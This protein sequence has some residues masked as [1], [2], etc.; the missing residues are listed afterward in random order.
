MPSDQESRRRVRHILEQDVSQVAKLLKIWVWD[1]RSGNRK[2]PIPDP[3][4]RIQGQKGT[5]SRIRIRNTI[6][7]HELTQLVPKSLPVKLNESDLT[8]STNCVNLWF[9]VDL[10]GTLLGWCDSAKLHVV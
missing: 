1:P 3:I 2:K 9:G 6:P 4:S 8:E 5:G 10:F 7:Y